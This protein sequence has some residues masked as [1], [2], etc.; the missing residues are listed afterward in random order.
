MAQQFIEAA[1]D[2]CLVLDINADLFCGRSVR[3]AAAEQFLLVSTWCTGSQQPLQFC[4][5]LLFTVLGSTVLEHA[6]QSHEYFHVS[7]TSFLS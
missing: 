3:A 6:H 5:T 7:V 2:L 1:N 4:I